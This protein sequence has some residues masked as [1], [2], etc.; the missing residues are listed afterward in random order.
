MAVLTVMM[1]WKIQIELRKAFWKSKAVLLAVMKICSWKYLSTWENVVHSP[2]NRKIFPGKMSS[3]RS[4]QKNSDRKALT[5]LNH[6]SIKEGRGCKC[7]PHLLV[8]RLFQVH[9]KMTTKM[10]H[11]MQAQII[12]RR[13]ANQASR[14]NYRNFDFEFRDILSSSTAAR[15]VQNLIHI[16]C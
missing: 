15:C 13:T 11:E 6:F 2:R 1:T 3:G 10:R 9:P 14:I 12:S 16:H 7:T 5:K 4:Q 8:S